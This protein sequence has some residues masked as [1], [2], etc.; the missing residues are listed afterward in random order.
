MN[1]HRVPAA[2]LAEAKSIGAPLL[3][4]DPSSGMAFGLPGQSVQEWRARCHDLV[5]SQLRPAAALK[6]TVSRLEARLDAALSAALA[7]GKMMAN[8]RGGGRGGAGA[9]ADAGVGAGAGGER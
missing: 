6:P 1:T 5:L 8:Q 9:G 2:V 7:K 3:A 4:L